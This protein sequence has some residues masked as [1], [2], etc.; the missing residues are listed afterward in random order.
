LEIDVLEYILKMRYFETIR[1]K[2]SGSYGVSVNS[3]VGMFPYQN[4]YFNFNFDC[5][6]RKADEL[7]KIIYREIMQIQ[8]QGPTLNEIQKTLEYLR[9]TRNENINKNQFWQKALFQKYYF[10]FDIDAVDNYDDQLKNISI[11]SIK[12]AANRFFDMNNYIELIS[13]PE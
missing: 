4:Y 13:V 12:S 2:E 6:P 5:D 7:V 8:E 1:E 10:G 3:K 9:K 11:E